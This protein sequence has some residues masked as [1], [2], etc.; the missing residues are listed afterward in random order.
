VIRFDHIGVAAYA[1]RTSAHTLATFPGA[2]EP[3]ADGAEDDMF[4][5]TS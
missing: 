2:S 5:P 4:R 3:V 1:P